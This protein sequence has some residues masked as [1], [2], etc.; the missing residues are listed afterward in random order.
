MWYEQAIDH[1]L[2]DEATLRAKIA[3]LGA[4]ITADYAGQAGRL[5]LVGVLKGAL[6]FIVDLSRAISLPVDYAGFDIPD[7]FV[8]GYGLDYNQIYRNLPFVGVLKP[9]FYTQPG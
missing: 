8:V 3:E 4:R 7:E 9:Q 5:V 6:P 2:I 1:V